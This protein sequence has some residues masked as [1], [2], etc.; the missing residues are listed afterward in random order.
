MGGIQSVTG[1]FRIS[2]LSR[3]RGLGDTVASAHGLNMGWGIGEHHGIASPGVSF[4]HPW[5]RVAYVVNQHAF[6]MVIP[7]VRTRYRAPS[8]PRSA[9]NRLVA[10]SRRLPSPDAFAAVQSKLG[11][12]TFKRHFQRPTRWWRDG[13]I[14][15]GWRAGHQ[16]APSESPHLAA[17]R[18][19]LRE[20]SRS[21]RALVPA[22]GIVE[23]AWE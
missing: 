11:A 19:L 3:F 15:S 1:I 6:L 2:V 8:Q 14:L 12:P 4:A 17:H 13:R 5:E 22:V 10:A 20:V 23:T 7:I 21:L 16:P 9:R 18:R